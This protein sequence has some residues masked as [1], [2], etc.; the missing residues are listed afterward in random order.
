A[1]SARAGCSQAGPGRQESRGF[2]AEEGEGGRS[3]RVQQAHDCRRFRGHALLQAS[4]VPETRLEIQAAARGAENATR[5]AAAG[6]TA[7]APGA[8]GT[9]V[10][11][12]SA[13]VGTDH[14]AP[15]AVE[16]NGASPTRRPA[17]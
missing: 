14:H 13:P 1:L 7:G 16:A 12:A 8:R 2:T 4:A 17:F 5:A 10:R 9:A 15:A 6:A 3:K 11:R